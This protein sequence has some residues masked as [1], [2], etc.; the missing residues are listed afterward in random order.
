MR[1]GF[2]LLITALLLG[3]STPEDRARHVEAEVENM[4]TVFGPGCERLGYVKDT[5]PWRE[6]ILRLSARDD[7][8]IGTAAKDCTAHSGFYTCTAY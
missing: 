7:Y 4:I 5:D 2:M 1:F 3:C 8:G 6:C